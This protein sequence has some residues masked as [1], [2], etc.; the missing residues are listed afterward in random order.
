MSGV[1]CEAPVGAGA[2]A[3]D[4]VP[5]SFPIVTQR[6]GIK[7]FTSEYKNWTSFLLNCKES[8][9]KLFYLNELDLGP[10]RPKSW[11]RRRMADSIELH[12]HRRR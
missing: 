6:Q 1:T 7:I 5:P 10:D 2:G 11:R 12:K 9:L 4:G 3:A 8:L